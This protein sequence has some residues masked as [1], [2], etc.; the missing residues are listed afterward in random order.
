MSRMPL[1]G[2]ARRVAL[3]TG[4]L[5][6]LAGVAIVLYFSVGGRFGAVNDTLN[7][8]FATTSGLLA[9]LT[10]R[11]TGEVVDTLAAAVGVLGAAVMVYGSYL[12]LSDSTGWF[13]AGVVSAV[14]GGL[15]GLWLVLLNRPVAGATPSLVRTMRLGR[16]AGAVM[17]LGLLGVGAWVSGVDDWTAAPWYVQLGLLGWI[18]T[19]AVYPAWCFAA[20][21]RVSPRGATPFMRDGVSA[22]TGGW[23]R[24]PPRPA[25]RS[26]GAPSAGAPS[27]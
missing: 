1:S 26:G 7:A 14:G 10:M 15:L 27:A 25:S 17:G 13:L 9:L 21:R 12:I 6:V 24:V 3:I 4:V 22:P 16:I 23:R 18:G 8:A 11:R 2:H 20:Y 5:V 19:Y